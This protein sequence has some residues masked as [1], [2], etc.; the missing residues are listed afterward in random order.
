[1]IKAVSIMAQYS[2]HSGL[3]IPLVVSALSSNAEHVALL[4]DS[5]ATFELLRRWDDLFDDGVAAIFGIEGSE[6]ELLAFAFHGSKFSPGA[7]AHWLVERGF[8]PLAFRPNSGKLAATGCDAARAARVRRVVAR[9]GTNG[10][11]RW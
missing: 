2:G 7:A 11:R 8:K 4:V 3:T 10:G 1:M 9:N 5:A 6:A